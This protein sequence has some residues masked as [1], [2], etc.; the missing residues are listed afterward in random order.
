[1]RGLGRVLILYLGKTE[2]KQI[3]KKNVLLND[4]C[5]NCH[6]DDSQVVMSAYDRGPN[7]S[8]ESGKT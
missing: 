7:L 1:M 2:I 5:H 8:D 4:N 3:S 6:T